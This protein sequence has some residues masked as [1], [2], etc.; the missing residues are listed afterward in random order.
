MLAIAALTVGGLTACTG[1]EERKDNCQASTM[2]YQSEVGN[3]FDT[4][5]F[6]TGKGGGGGGGGRGG[7]SSS[8]SGNNSGNNS[9][10][11]N[12]NRNN[13]LTKDNRP[14]GSGGLTKDNSGP[15]KDSKRKDKHKDHFDD[16]YM[17]DDYYWDGDS[18]PHNSGKTNTHR[19]A[20]PSPSPSK[21]S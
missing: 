21:N 6:I 8:N 15:T 3:D 1:G 17:D 11:N 7:S 20:S 4:V 13:G 10:S 14:G 9:N 18:Q 19:C 2:S 16:D 12:T 5:A